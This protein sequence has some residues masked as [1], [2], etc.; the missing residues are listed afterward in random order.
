MAHRGARPR[1]GGLEGGD[2]GRDLNV[3][4]AP[5]GIVL[6]VDQLVDQRGHRVDAGVA[7]AEKAH[8]PPF[9]GEVQSGPDPLLLLPERVGVEVFSPRKRPGQVDVELIPHQISR[10][11]EKVLGLGGA[12][13]R[14]AGAQPDDKKLPA[15]PARKWLEPGAFFANPEGAGGAAAFLFFEGERFSRTKRSPL[16]PE[17]GENG[18]LGDPVAAGFRENDLGGVGEPRRL[19]LE[20][21]GGE[22]TERSAKLLGQKMKSRLV[23]LE[24]DG[25][26]QSGRARIEAEGI[27]GSVN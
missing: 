13:H 15:R 11:G 8:A 25:D 17:G 26:N 1:G 23:G 19:P 20:S 16:R 4:S 2:A 12:P 10:T 21:G 3:Q 7:R 27:E 5:L 22:K 14:I 9:P 18:A 24:R 6:P